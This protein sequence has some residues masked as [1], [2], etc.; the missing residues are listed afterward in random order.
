MSSRDLFEEGDT[1]EAILR[2]DPALR[3]AA[4]ASYMDK[5]NG[6]GAHVVHNHDLDPMC[7]ETRNQRGWLVGECVASQ[8]R[9][10]LHGMPAS[11]D[12]GDTVPTEGEWITEELWTLTSVHD[13]RA[14]TT[15]K[16]RLYAESILTKFPDAF[17]LGRVTRQVTP[18]VKS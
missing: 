1:G 8:P 16:R 2:R 4:L 6:K 13:D 9:N 7:K 12:A 15:Y 17:T 14:V 11:R 18:W 3:A 5:V 10:P